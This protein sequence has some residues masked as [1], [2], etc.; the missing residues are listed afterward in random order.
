MTSVFRDQASLW[1]F[2]HLTSVFYVF[3]AV[4]LNVISL[5]IHVYI[6]KKKNLS[7]PK[8][9]KSIYYH[10]VLLAGSLFDKFVNLAQLLVLAL[11]MPSPPV[12]GALLMV[13]VGRVTIIW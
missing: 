6:F 5:N 10:C 1:I 7:A 13:R 11:Q 2:T 12:S 8:S 9:P 3:C 4:F